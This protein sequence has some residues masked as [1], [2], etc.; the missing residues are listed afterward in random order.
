MPLAKSLIFAAITGDLRLIRATIQNV[1]YYTK[2][3]YA[4]YVSHR[5]KKLAQ[6]SLHDLILT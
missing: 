1:E 2:R 6:V 3:N 5:K 4:A